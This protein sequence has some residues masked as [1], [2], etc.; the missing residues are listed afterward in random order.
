M[1]LRT[2]ICVKAFSI[3]LLQIKSYC[4]VYLIECNLGVSFKNGK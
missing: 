1:G 4:L 3:Y 2:V